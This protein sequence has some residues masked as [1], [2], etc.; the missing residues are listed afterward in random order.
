MN[1]QESAFRFSLELSRLQSPDDCAALFQSAIFPYGFDTFACGELDLRYRDRSVFHLI[2][3]PES[4]RKFYIA[5]GLIE[6]DPVVDALN[7]R[8]EP[9]T[10]SDLRADLTFSNLGREALKLA[11]EHGWSEGLIVPMPR[12]GS[13]VGLVSLAGHKADLPF[14]ALAYLCSISVF[15]HIHVRAMVA[16]AGFA[17]PPMGLTDR[18]I[19]CLRLVAKGLTDSQIGTE[20]GVSRSTAHEFVEKAKHRLNVKTRTELV[21]IATALGIIAL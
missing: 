2:G 19:I 1:N 7:E 3:W 10:W 18:E 5:S 21:A 9:F 6:R 13:R 20:M 8:R 4:W 12:S 11:A 17:Q 15:L 16:H 14:E